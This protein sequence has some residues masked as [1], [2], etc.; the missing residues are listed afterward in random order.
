MVIKQFVSEEYSFLFNS[1]NGLFM[2]WGKDFLRENSLEA[3][4]GG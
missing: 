4:Y 2:R 3:E 1:S